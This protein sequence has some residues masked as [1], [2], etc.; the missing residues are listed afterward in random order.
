M[1]AGKLVDIEREVE[2]G[3]PLHSKGVLILGGY[4]AA[5]YAQ[6][7]PMSLHATLVFEQ[8][9]GGVDGDSASCAE[10]CCLQSAI[11]DLPLRQDL[12]VTGSMNQLGEVQAIG[13]VNEK[14]EGF[15]DIC[16]KRGLSGEQGV[17]IPAANVKHLM[18][19]RDVVEA[20]ADKRFA[21][22]PVEHVDQALERL[23][24]L[25][26]GERGADGQFPDG[27][28]SRRVCDR[29]L[30]FADWRQSFARKEEN[31]GDGD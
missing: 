23:T 24:G 19:R 7:V 30:Q 14:I 12:A 3:G 28:I 29:L 15:F 11:A 18:L 20:V 27:T 9:Y 8:S 16:R 2:L 21:V 13:G 10:L 22:Y 6:D 25:P 26:A 4:L 1:G 5:R 31:T 17:L